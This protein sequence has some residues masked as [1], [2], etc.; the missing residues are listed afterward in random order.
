MG[1]PKIL[2]PYRS[3]RWDG[4]VLQF[5]AGAQRADAPADDAQDALWRTYYANIF[6][7]A[8]LIRT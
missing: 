8:R 3:V 6:N 1:I 5:G 4:A 7:P 2:T